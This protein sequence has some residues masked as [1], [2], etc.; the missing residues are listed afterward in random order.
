MRAVEQIT[1]A[2]TDHG[3]GPVWSPAWGGL[4]L[5]DMLVGDLL[6]LRPDGGVDRRHVGR[7]AAFVRPRRVGGY[8]VATE[9]GV[10][11]ADD[12]DGAPTRLVPVVSA[13]GIRMNEGTAAP[14]GS[15]YVGT[16]AWDQAP[17]AAGLYRID[18]AL[19]VEQVLDGVTIS[20]GMGFSPDGSRAYYVDSGTGRLDVFDVADG[21]LT[22]RRPLVERGREDGDLDGLAVDAQGTIWVAVYG[23]GQVLR[24][25]PAGNLLERVDLPV[26]HVTAC[27]LGGADMT[28]LFVTT[29]RGGLGPGAHPAAGAL[30]R[31]S[32]DVPG[33]PVVPFGG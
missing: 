28:D 10:E 5:V 25:D 15:L 11:L 2:V 23:A 13:P 19:K 27:T 22:D 29:S 16:S 12:V 8:V 26:P 3:E 9:L 7:V 31:V 17:G 6:T 30:F 4:R 24:F 33:L 14:D 21:R 32:V 18:P 1:D 20:N